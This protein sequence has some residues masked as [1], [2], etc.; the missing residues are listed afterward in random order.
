[1]K[2][3]VSI[4]L[5]DDDSAFCAELARLFEKEDSSF[6]LI[7]SFTTPQ[8]AIAEIPRIRPRV[9]LMDI[10]LSKTSSGIDCVRSLSAQLPD[11]RFLMLTALHD[12][13]SLFESLK[14]GASGYLLK[15]DVSEKLFPSI[16]TLLDGGLPMSTSVARRVLNHFRRMDENPEILKLLTPKEEAVLRSMAH[17]SRNKEIAAQMGISPITI[18]THTRNIF[19]KLKVSSRKEAVQKLRSGS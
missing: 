13:A 3:V 14:A 16:R 7:G 18:E 8:K 11:V 4:V 15:R 12:S 5:V 1:M 2:Q 10:G 6:S 9:V 19:E 17:G